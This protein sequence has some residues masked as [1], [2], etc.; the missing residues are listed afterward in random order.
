MTYY[1]QNCGRTDIRIVPLYDADYVPQE[2]DL[3]LLEPSRRFRETQEFFDQLANS[4]MPHREVRVGPISASTIYLYE[5]TA[6]SAKETPGKA[7]AQGRQPQ[8]CCG[9]TPAN[10]ARVSANTISMWQ[11]FMR[12]QP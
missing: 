12:Y 9:A 8:A 2:G 11:P 10:S 7:F 3:V 6:L 4:S 5:S 1:L